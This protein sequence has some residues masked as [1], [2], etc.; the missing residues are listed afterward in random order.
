M[1]LQKR[2]TGKHAI[3][4]HDKFPLRWCCRENEKVQK[5]NSESSLGIY[6]SSA[7]GKCQTVHTRVTVPRGTWVR[8]RTNISLLHKSTQISFFRHPLEE[9][10]G[11]ITRVGVYC[12][13][14]YGVPVTF[15]TTC[16][17]CTYVRLPLRW[18]ACST[19]KERGLGKTPTYVIRKTHL[20]TIILPLSCRTLH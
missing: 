14:F 16:L 8:A 3:E 13:H 18:R 7:K 15:L 2:Y 19:G 20:S 12:S 5:C 17:V 4:K 10:G 11:S 9:A 1:V 6:N